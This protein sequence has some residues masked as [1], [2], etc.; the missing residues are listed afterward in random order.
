MKTQKLEQ[1]EKDNS[2]LNKAVS[3]NTYKLSSMILEYTAKNL[4]L[5]EEVHFEQVLDVFMEEFPE[6]V[7]LIAEENF[8]RGYKQGLEDQMAWKTI[9]ES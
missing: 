3:K 8:M 1:I 2:L 7:K 9:H 6:F 5:N 4:G